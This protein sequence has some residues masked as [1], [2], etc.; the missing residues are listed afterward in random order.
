M[1]SPRPAT[2]A[3]AQSQQRTRLIACGASALLFVLACATPAMTVFNTGQR[4]EEHLWGMVLLLLGWLGAFMFQFGWYA[5][6]LLALA[7]VLLLAGADRKAFW[8]GCAAC[9]LGLSSLTWYVNPLLRCLR[10][11]NRRPD[12]SPP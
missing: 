8:V 10:H 5:N 12:L 11:P 9:I 2:S 3:H 1:T 7:F 4:A 6:L